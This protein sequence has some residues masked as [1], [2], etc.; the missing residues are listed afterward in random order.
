[1]ALSVDG[2]TILVTG[3]NSGI[4]YAGAL[5]LSR[6]GARVI[7]TSR[8]LARAEEAAARI[9]AETGNTAI[10]LALDLSSQAAINAFADAVL[11]RFERLDVLVNN[12]GALWTT[13][14]ESA[15]GYEMTWA[16]NH[17]GPFLLTAR[18]LPLLIRTGGARIVTTAS[19]AHLAGTIAFENLGLPGSFSRSGA[20]DGPS[21]AMCCSLSFWPAVS[22]ARA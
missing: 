18:L 17:L 10:G 13:R 5:A 19:R 1:M 20:M 9:A 4:G 14:Q 11:A 15:D 21:S 6:A 16:V 3:G 8:S 12:A 2:K 7:V 22:R